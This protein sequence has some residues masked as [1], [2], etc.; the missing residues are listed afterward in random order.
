MA[1]GPETM[2]EFLGDILENVIENVIERIDEPKNLRYRRGVSSFEQAGRDRREK[3]KKADAA[4]TATQRHD[5]QFESCASEIGFQVLFL[6]S[7]LRD[8]LFLARKSRCC[9]LS[10]AGLAQLWRQLH[11]SF[12]CLLCTYS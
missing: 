8:F 6:S 4:A 11:L 3:E 2:D 9:W 10:A 1:G 7:A 5:R 12:L